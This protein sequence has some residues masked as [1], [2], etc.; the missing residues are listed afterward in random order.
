MDTTPNLAL[1]LMAAAQAQKHVT[2]NEAILALDALVQLA[3]LDKDLALPPASPIEGDRYLVANSSPGGAWAGWSGRIAFYRDGGWDSIVPRAG[4]LAWVADE[5]GFYVR[6]DAG[7]I[8]LAAALGALQGLARL[9][10]GTSADAQNPFAAKLNKALWTARTAAEGGDGDLRYT[11]NKEAAA[12]TLSLLF[13][14]GFSA[15]AEL[16][17]VG[18][19]DLR[20]KVS[21]DGA[22]FTEA[23]A[24]DRATGNVRL[25]GAWNTGHLVLG[26][27][28]LWIDASG[29]LRIK[30]GSPASATDGAVAGTQA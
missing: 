9:G 13:Q 12:D 7:W 6:T 28:H 5:G 10:I 23:L 24:V 27:H 17:L 8:G 26:A 21:A 18:D 16:G 11:L 3:C 20:L 1:P 25:P 2:H 14:T 4:H 29:R 19:D 30:A 15:R 22:A